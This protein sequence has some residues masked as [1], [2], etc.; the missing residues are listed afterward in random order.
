MS[1]FER[2]VDSQIRSI[3][4]L[5]PTVIEVRVS[6]QDSALGF[7]WIDL[8]LE[9]SNVSEANLIDNG[10]LAYLDMTEG[11]SIVFEDNRFAF[12]YGDYSS[13]RSAKDSAL[14]VICD[15][16]KYEELPFSG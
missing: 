11:M 15:S 5:S 3:T 6:T 13:I 10:K 4:V 16:I 7:D 1:R 2:F 9:L 12:C 14:F 8:S